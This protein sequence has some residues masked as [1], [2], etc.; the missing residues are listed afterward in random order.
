MTEVIIFAKQPK[1][2][3]AKTRLIPALGAERAAQ[4]A[5]RL[6]QRTVAEASQL[7]LGRVHFCYTPADWL[8]A[9]A[10]PWPEVFEFCEQG[11]GDLGERMARACARAQRPV[12]VMGTDCPA[13]SA[14]LLREMA[15]SLQDYDACMIPALD[16]GYVA[17]AMREYRPA[18][19]ENITWSTARVAEQTRQRMRE[20]DWRWLELPPL[21]DIDTAEDL[22]WLP[23]AWQQELKLFEVNPYE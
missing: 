20:L 10:Y 6:L 2:G 15:S 13:L 4:L 21:A 16:G 14:E 5:E 9:A 11:E 1:P 8:Y 18:I 7:G 22:H 19:F 23:Q 17:L 3:F 12:L